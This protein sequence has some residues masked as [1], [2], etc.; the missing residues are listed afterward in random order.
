[1]TGEGSF[2][3]GASRSDISAQVPRIIEKLTSK[4]NNLELEG[5]Q[6]LLSELKRAQY[7]IS[8]KGVGQVFIAISGI[9]D[10][11]N[12]RLQIQ[13]PLLKC[14]NDLFR[15]IGSISDQSYKATNKLLKSVS[16]F[17]GNKNHQ[18]KD[19]TFE[20]L[21]NYAE[22][23]DIDQIFNYSIENLSKNNQDCSKMLIEFFLKYESKLKQVDQ[24]RCISPVL[25]SLKSR[26][27]EIKKLGKQLLAKLLGLVPIKLF[28]KQI[29]KE[30]KLTIQSELKKILKE[31]QQGGH[32]GSGLPSKMEIED[33]RA[34]STSNNVRSGPRFRKN[35]KRGKSRMNKGLFASK[36]NSSHMN[37]NNFKNDQ[38][39]SSSNHNSHEKNRFKSRRLTSQDRSGHRGRRSGGKAYGRSSNEFADSNAFIQQRSN[40]ESRLLK[41]TSKVFSLYDLT[42]ESVNELF[43]NIKDNFSKELSGQLRSWDFRK[44]IQ[45][46]KSLKKA[47]ILEA[48]EFL[49]VLDIIVRWFFVKLF[50]NCNQNFGRESFTFLIDMMTRMQEVDYKIDHKDGK[51]LLAAI[52]GRLA[53]SSP[54]VSELAFQSLTSMSLIIEQPILFKMVLEQ[55]QKVRSKQIKRQIIRW[56][57][58]QINTDISPKQI[59]FLV[60]I[61][62]NL[63]ESTSKL[64]IDEVFYALHKKYGDGCLKFFVKHLSPK[65]VQSIR[66]SIMKKAQMLK[67]QGQ[68]QMEVE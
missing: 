22:E 11:K 30:E 40:R 7:S 4:K 1:M 65:V 18:I 15:S 23:N 2:G 8:E 68:T 67:D 20:C 63:K 31:V 52:I 38:T 51:I 60:N 21:T 45:A 24:K 62:R 48:K 33:Q 59:E 54:E 39:H 32:V 34:R 50:D 44:N 66:N 26:H 6:D 9:L 53:L 13:K 57:V 47:L 14:T 10:Q 55:F 58:V 35:R 64:F 49:Q 5:T 17:I 3:N 46:I 25:C 37:Q 56:I 42:D 43:H 29:M 19:L 41:N 28:S 36:K 12:I 27:P 61:Y 16:K